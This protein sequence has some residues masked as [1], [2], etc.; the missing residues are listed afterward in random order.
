MT[1]A[2]GLA[3]LFRVLVRPLPLLLML[4]LKARVVLAMQ[5]S[6]TPAIAGATFF[7]T[8][9]SI[10]DTTLSRF[11]LWIT[12]GVNLTPDDAGK[13]R[14]RNQVLGETTCQCNKLIINN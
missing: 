5:D 14:I 3:I 11:V 12:S 2:R 8:A 1:P 4:F 10:L 7:Q 9:G 13:V 6:R